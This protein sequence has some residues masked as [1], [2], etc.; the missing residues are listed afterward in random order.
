MYLGTSGISAPDHP[1][2]GQVLGC[3]TGVDELAVCAPLTLYSNKD[4]D[5]D[6][7]TENRLK[8]KPEPPRSCLLPSSSAVVKIQ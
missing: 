5:T 8:S 6:S 1:L 2:L 7:L 3:W 4:E